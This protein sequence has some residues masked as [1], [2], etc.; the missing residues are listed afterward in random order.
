[1][2]WSPDGKLLASGSQDGVIRLTE[3][4][5]GKE[6][7][8]LNNQGAVQAL[9]F[10]HDGSRLGVKTADGALS[11]FDTAKGQRTGTLNLV[12]FQAGH[13]AFSLDGSRLTAAGVGQH[14]IWNHTMG[15]AGGS[16]QGN[17]PADAF[18][19]VSPNGSITAWGRADGNLH[20][21]NV[22]TQSYRN[23]VVGPA[24]AL[25]FGPKTQLMAIAAKDKS[26]RLWEYGAGREVRRLEGLTEPAKLLVFSANGKTLAAATGSLKDPLIRIWDVNSGRLRRQVTGIKGIAVALT[27]APDGRTLAVATD[28]TKAVLWNVALREVTRPTPPLVLSVKELHALWGNLA[29]ADYTEADEAFRRLAATGNLGVPFLKQQ[30]RRVAVPPVDYQRIDQLL[31]ELDSPRFP[32]RDRAKAELTKYGE[33]AGERPAQ[34]AGPESAPGS[35]AADREIAGAGGQSAPDA[36]ARAGAGGSG[37]A[38]IA[39]HGGGAAGAG[40]NRPRGAAAADSAG[41]GGGVGAAEDAGQQGVRLV[42]PRRL[43]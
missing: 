39:G 41:S 8:T 18:A 5:T 34:I 6:R 22:D 25:A 3:A 1:M 32:V 13:L 20:C 12:G 29:S 33:L 15:G 4:A 27:L 23:L 26:I 28:D 16:R 24:V 19:A 10:S 43:T 37:V 21:Y 17:L 9:V 38:G 40:G 11:M 35:A 30:V 7:L 2:A 31:A 14:L 42:L 36:G